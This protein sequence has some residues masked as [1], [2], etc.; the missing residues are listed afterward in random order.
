MKKK[1]LQYCKILTE[2]KNIKSIVNDLINIFYDV[3]LVNE[4]A[5]LLRIMFH[6]TNKS[7]YLL[8]AGDLFVGSMDNADIGY[9]LYDLYFQ[10]TNPQFYERYKYT[11]SKMT[12]NQIPF[13]ID[14][15][16][17]S[18]GIINLTDRYNIIVCIMLY[19]NQY[20]MVE[21]ILSAKIFLDIIKD[22]ITSYSDKNIQYSYKE[23]LYTINKMLVHTL[24]LNED[25]L[26]INELAL[27]ID[28]KQ[29]QAY[30]NLINIYV[31]DGQYD[32][33]FNVYNDY[34]KNNDKPP[35]RT[36]SE[37]LWAVDKMYAKRNMIYRAIK[38]QKY[39]SE[40]DLE[41]SGGN[42]A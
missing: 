26:K 9:A 33:A 8:R 28:K 23:E 10:K 34:C 7:E 35:A 29:E 13:T 22:K 15:T 4:Q 24:T 3:G 12:N 39:V 2:K 31:S 38:Y 1:L 27:S 40:Y 5:N 30:L 16:D 18:D 11:L 36:V 20:H 25:N 19:F 32:K 42:N 6:L 21:D 37:M 17:Y 41:K 14:T